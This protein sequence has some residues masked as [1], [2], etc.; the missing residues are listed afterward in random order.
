MSTKTR[1]VLLAAFVTL[2]AGGL[3][4]IRPW[5]AGAGRTTMTASTATYTVRLFTDGP[6]EGANTFDFEITARDGT[7][8]HLDEVTLQPV[9]PQMGHAYPPV[10]AART[11]PGRYRAKDTMLAMTGYWR[12]NVTLRR[13]NDAQQAA[14]TLLAK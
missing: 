9:M 12:I 6:R 13:A 11:A 10:T 8:A 14:F 7:P 1:F 3:L 5:L 2:L 4:V